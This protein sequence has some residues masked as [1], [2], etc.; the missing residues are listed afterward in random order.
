MFRIAGN[1]AYASVSEDS[2]GRQKGHGVVQY[3]TEE[4]AANA[5]KTMRQHPC[6]FS[7]SEI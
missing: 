6:L 2:N 4:E 7:M 1:V 3:E 5:I